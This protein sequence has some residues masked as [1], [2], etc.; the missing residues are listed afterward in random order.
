MLKIN[1]CKLVLDN[2]RR[3]LSLLTYFMLHSLV[4]GTVHLHTFKMN[5]FDVFVFATR[6]VGENL[7]YALCYCYVCSLVIG[8]IIVPTYEANA[9]L[10]E[11]V[12]IRVL[13]RSVLQRSSA[14]L[15]FFD[16]GS[17]LCLIISIYLAPHQMLET[18]IIIR[19]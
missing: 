11:T 16:I 14:E 4:H 2:V 10:T 18:N 1:I 13:Q 6:N 8:W 15:L 7:G 3:S 17:D 19:H 9:F 12:I 5:K